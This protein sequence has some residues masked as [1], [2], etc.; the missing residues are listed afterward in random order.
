VIRVT[1]ATVASSMDFRFHKNYHSFERFD[2]TGAPF[3]YRDGETKK[4]FELVYNRLREMAFRCRFADQSHFSKRFSNHFGLTIR[5][6]IWS[7]HFSGI[8]PQN[9]LMI[10]K[11]ILIHGASQ[12][13]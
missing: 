12:F 9:Q 2:K 3:A 13:Y 5:I 7:N 1:D 11:E 10:I 8:Y 6:L 4:M